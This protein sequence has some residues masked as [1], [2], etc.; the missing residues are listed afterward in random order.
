[1]KKLAPASDALLG[2]VIE[3]NLQIE[4]MR[5]NHKLRTSSSARSHLPKLYEIKRSA[6]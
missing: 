2:K 5:Q 1:M 6:S 4:A 3:K